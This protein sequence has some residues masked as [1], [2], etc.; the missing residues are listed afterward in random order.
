V[1]VGVEDVF[2]AVGAANVEVFVIVEE[3]DLGRWE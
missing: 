1:A 2:L 3:E